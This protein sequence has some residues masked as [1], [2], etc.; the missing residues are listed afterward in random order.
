[1]K[2]TTI[3]RICLEPIFNYLCAEC[4]KKDVAKWLS[5]NS[6]ALEIQFKDFDAKLKRHFSTEQNTEYCMKCRN[7]IE[8]VFC[9]FCYVR[10]I[11]QWIFFK[12][13]WLAQKFVKLFNFDFAGTGFLQINE[14]S[15]LSP[16]ILAEKKRKSDINICEE[17][18]QVSDDLV[19]LNGEWKCES[20]RDEYAEIY[21]PSLGG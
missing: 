10:E 15:N 16:V 21:E 19:E 13:P 9:I 20:C 12:D 18:G 17:C 11:F 5:S 4:L 2:E 14:I 3:C 8:S 7:E 6:P 1:M